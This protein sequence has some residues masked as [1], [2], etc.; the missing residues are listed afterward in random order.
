MH[1]TGRR[2]DGFE[3]SRR[4]CG[5]SPLRLHSSHSSVHPQ[6]LSAIVDSGRRCLF[7]RKDSSLEG[8]AVDC[9]SSPGK[10]YG[11][12]RDTLSA[13]AAA[14]TM[15]G[16]CRGS[17]TLWLTLAICGVAILLRVALAR[18][19]RADTGASPE[20]ARLLDRSGGE[21]DCPRMRSGRVRLDL[22][23]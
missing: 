13:N 6:S 12:Q 2:V 5:E 23:R 14:R 15:L 3:L 11:R 7:F 1:R 20:P 8:L 17:G 21:S 22:R 9:S 16:H 18:R 10:F 19:P 4:G